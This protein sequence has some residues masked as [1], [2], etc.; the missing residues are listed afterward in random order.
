MEDKVGISEHLAVRSCC[1]N[2]FL[3]RA[4]F[5]RWFKGNLKPP[6]LSAFPPPLLAKYIYTHLLNVP[7][8]PFWLVDSLLKMI[9]PKDFLSTRVTGLLCA[10]SNSHTVNHTNQGCN[11][12]VSLGSMQPSKVRTPS[13]GFATAV[14]PDWPERRTSKEPPKASP[15]NSFGGYALAPPALHGNVGLR[16]DKLT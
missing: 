10:R 11:R 7:F 5:W 4:P 12:G 8:P 13:I 3:L 6:I 9:N 2:V 14:G 1:G 15:D 16:W